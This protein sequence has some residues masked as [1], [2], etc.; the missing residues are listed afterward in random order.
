MICADF[1]AGA[2]QDNNEKESLL[3]SI[4]RMF[5]LL[6]RANESNLSRKTTEDLVSALRQQRARLGLDKQGYDELRK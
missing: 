1:L 3:L 4:N 2:S 5:E 6:P